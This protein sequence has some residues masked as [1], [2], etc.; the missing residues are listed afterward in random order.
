MISS[1]K[2]NDGKFVDDMLLVDELKE[3]LAR[4]PQGKHLVILH[5]EGSHY[6]YSQR[7]PSSFV[8]YQPECIGVDQACSKAQLI[9]AFDNSV[10]YTDSFIDNVIDQVRDK[11]A[12]VFYAADH[13][14]SIDE[15][16]H[17]HGTPRDMAPP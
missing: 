6:L 5:T 1:E 4:H 14:E 8:R 12:L 15:N 11:K 17:L 10:L 3:S 13:G 9:N 7:Y 2:R 16:Y